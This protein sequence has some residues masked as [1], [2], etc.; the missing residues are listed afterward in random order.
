MAQFAICQRGFHVKMLELIQRECLNES[1]HCFATAH[2]FEMR[3]NILRQR[4]RMLVFLG[5]VVPAT[6]GLTFMSFGGNSTLTTAL[7][8]L[9]SLLLILQ[10]V[11]S[12]WSLVQRWDD[13]FAYALESMSANRLFYEQFNELASDT[14]S[15]EEANIRYQHLQHESQTRSKEDEKQGFTE[16][17]KRLGMCAGLRQLQRPCAGCHQIPTSMTPSSC[18]VCGNFRVPGF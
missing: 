2:I 1:L 8:V 16:N 18:N 13:N 7:V 10:L 12:V 15:Q 14:L 3:A 11:G 6:V 9:G 17:E 5:I 4:I